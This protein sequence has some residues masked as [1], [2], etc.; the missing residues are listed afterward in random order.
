MSTELDANLNC[1]SA[2][3]H[4]QRSAKTIDKGRYPRMN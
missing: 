2:V 3:R 4:A 1:T